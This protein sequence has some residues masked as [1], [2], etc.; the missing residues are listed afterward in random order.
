MSTPAFL[1]GLAGVILINIVL[2]GDNA[3]VIALAV[4]TLP[5][6]K[7]KWGLFAGAG[8]AVLLRI[9][10]TLVAV[11]LIQI[12]YLKLGGGLIILWIALKLL[13]ENEERNS[14]GREAAT[15]LHAVWIITV[16]DVTMSLENVLAVAGASGGSA[17]LLWIGLGLSIPLV[18][19]ASGLLSRLMDRFPAI[20][21]LGAAILGGVGGEMI[22]G[23]A[24]I[25]RHSSLPHL[26]TLGQ[27]AG[28]VLIL[29]AAAWIQF[30]RTKTSASPGG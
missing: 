11:R 3:I 29:A 21:V 15:L 30:R 6:A 7:R 17:L 24:A 1:A 26:Q 4:K 8:V 16:A 2:S 28:A 20:A 14:S 12:P 13:S 22:A 9:A 23:D 27:V 19:F 5:P 25:Q 18:M 10:F